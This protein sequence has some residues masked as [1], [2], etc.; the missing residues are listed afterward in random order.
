M[1]KDIKMLMDNSLIIEKEC[2]S[3]VLI[4]KNGIKDELLRFRDNRNKTGS[5]KMN[6]YTPARF[7]DTIK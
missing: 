3:L 6:A 1:E 7:V 2:M 4:E 5:Y